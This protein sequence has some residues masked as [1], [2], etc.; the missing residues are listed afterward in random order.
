MHG[1]SRATKAEAL[2]SRLRRLASGFRGFQWPSLN[3]EGSRLG[4]LG[5]WHLIFDV[6]V[7]Q[8]LIFLICRKILKGECLLKKLLI[9][10]R[11]GAAQLLLN[12]RPKNV[13]SITII[14]MS[15]PYLFNLL[16][17]LKKI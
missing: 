12:C 10:L 6:E 14:R 5:I 1:A 15:F 4:S 16:W 7:S 8:Q 13:I 9:E 17:L 2:G 3:L 11:N